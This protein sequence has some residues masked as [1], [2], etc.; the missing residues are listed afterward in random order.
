MEE[1]RIT[2]LRTP[3]A[4]TSKVKT[5]PAAWD[6]RAGKYL[7]AFGIDETAYLIYDEPRLSLTSPIFPFR[8]RRPP[9]NLLRLLLERR[10]QDR[11]GHTL[12]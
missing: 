9:G 5:S 11:G 4:L 2:H 10:Q 7:C 12:R 8:L 3:M 1:V 6:E